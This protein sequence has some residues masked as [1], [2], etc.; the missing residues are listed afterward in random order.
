VQKIKNRPG[1]LENY[2]GN[3]R[4]A[5]VIKLYIKYL[6]DSWEAAIVRN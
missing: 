3:F 4:K 2:F 1:G 6:T 5:E